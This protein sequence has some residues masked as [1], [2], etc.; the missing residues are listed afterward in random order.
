MMLEWAAEQGTEITRDA[1]DLEFLPTN[2]NVERVVQNLQCVMQQMHTALMAL[3]SYETNDIVANS[4]KN[5]LEA[6]R[7]YVSRY[8]QK[9]KSKIE[10]EIKLAGLD[11]LVP[12]ELQKHLI[13]N[14]NRLRTFEEARLEIVTY[15]EAKFGL[16]IRGARPGEA[17]SCAQSDPMDVDAVNSLATG[18]GK[19]STVPHGGCFTCGGAH[20]QRDCNA[21]K[22]KSKQSSGKGK[23]NGKSWSKSESR[24][25]G[26][27]N[28]GTSE[29]KIER[30]QG[31]ETFR[32]W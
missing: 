13:L 26:R 19:A 11:A 23:R 28:N 22:G 27:E 16:R 14:T 10:D 9:L 32:R 31:I 24:G 18:K 7:R 2:T 15:V 5:P 8:E 4:R 3:T 6:W 21:R 30:R 29:E 25:K 1:I 17:V 12:E 20:H